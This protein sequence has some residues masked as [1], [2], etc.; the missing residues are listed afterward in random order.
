MLEKSLRFFQREQYIA[1]E[2]KEQIENWEKNQATPLSK[3]LGVINA[4]RKYGTKAAGKVEESENYEEGINYGKRIFFPLVFA[5][6]L[7][8]EY[9]DLFPVVGK[10]IKVVALSIIWYNILVVGRSPGY[11]DPKY[12]VEIGWKI[13]LFFR[14][15][16]LADLIPFVSAL[17][18]TTISVLIVWYK[19]HKQIKEKEGEWQKTQSEG[20]YYANQL[21]EAEV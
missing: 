6:S 21:N 13:R 7:A 17:P 11:L 16:G 20:N 18:L 2:Y 8:S 5:C 12:K 3:R 19:T 4:F 10:V 1:P 14:I 9:T 15:L